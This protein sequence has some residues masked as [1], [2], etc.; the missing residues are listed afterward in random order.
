MLVVTP[1]QQNIKDLQFRGHDY[2][3]F[4]N[5]VMHNPDCAKEKEKEK[6]NYAE[7]VF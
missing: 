1:S 4:K 2:I 6:E 5:G 3:Q 7:T